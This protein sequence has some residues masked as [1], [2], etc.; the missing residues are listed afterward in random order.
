MFGERVRSGLVAPFRFAGGGVGVPLTPGGSGD[1]AVTVVM[2]GE[3]GA[4]FDV[5]LNNF[6]EE[7]SFEGFFSE[8]TRVTLEPTPTDSQVEEEEASPFLPRESR[9]VMGRDPT[10]LTLASGSICRDF[11]PDKEAVAREVRVIQDQKARE[12]VDPSLIRSWVH[13]ITQAGIR[14]GV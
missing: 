8:S 4:D 11:L 6:R 12:T 2:G 14:C 9:T 5:L 3:D 13:Q 10:E 1:A 7:D